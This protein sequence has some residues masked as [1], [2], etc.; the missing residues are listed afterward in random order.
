M[1]LSYADIFQNNASYQA[2]GHL[3][4]SV[5]RISKVESKKFFQRDR[6]GQFL[7]T[8]HLPKTGLLKHYGRR[9]VSYD[10]VRGEQLLAVLNACEKSLLCE[11]HD[12]IF[13]C[14][15]SAQRTT[16]AELCVHL[17]KKENGAYPHILAQKCIFYP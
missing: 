14:F 5:I 2:H 4:Y 1:R 15:E 3:F 8:T 11:Y 7:W 13:K 10:Y 12:R 9:L 6:R 16:Y 17:S